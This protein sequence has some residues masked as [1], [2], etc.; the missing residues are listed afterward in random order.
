MDSASI[1][2]AS[3]VISCDEIAESWT[4]KLYEWMV[5]KQCSGRAFDVFALATQRPGLQ[6][7]ILVEQK[8][9]NRATN[10]F[11]R[12]DLADDSDDEL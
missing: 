7:P 2:D 12:D 3:I 6:I 11:R 5:C 8:F 4:E 1:V 9:S 10:L